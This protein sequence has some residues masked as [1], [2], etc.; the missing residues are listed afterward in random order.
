[1]K[2]LATLALALATLAGGVIALGPRRAAAFGDTASLVVAQLRY[3]GDWNPRPTATRRLAWEVTRRTSIEMALEPHVVGLDDPDLFFYPLL[4]IA[5]TSDFA[6]WPE[7]GVRR[8]RRYLTA[9]GLLLAD[10]AD[11]GDGFDRALRRELGRIF[12]DRPLSRLAPEHVIYKTFFLVDRQ[13]GRVI[14]RPYMESIDVDGRTAVLYSHNDL[15]GAWARDG[16]GNW[17]YQVIP[18]GDSQREMTF[19]LGINIAMYAL[20]L[21]YKEDQV[22]LPFI[23]KRRR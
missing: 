21:D 5:G 12:P 19:R 10:S 13:G 15:G 4:Y 2:R 6:P 3:D 7:E 9:G 14:N 16:F 11:P 1:M 17:E 8:L 23:L 20:C 22:H 18:G